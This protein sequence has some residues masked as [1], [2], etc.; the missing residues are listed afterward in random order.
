M[1]TFIR[2]VSSALLAGTVLVVGT[3]PIGCSDDD[4]SGTTGRRVAL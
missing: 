4:G 2:V 3:G 1:S